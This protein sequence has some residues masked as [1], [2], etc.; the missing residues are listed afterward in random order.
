MEDPNPLIWDQATKAM[1]RRL[2]ERTALPAT[3]NGHQLEDQ[4]INGF[5]DPSTLTPEHDEP[6]FIE[7]DPPPADAALYSTLST[8]SNGR[9]SHIPTVKGSPIWERLPQEPLPFYHAY[10]YY[11]D[12]DNP[13]SLK[14]VATALRGDP[15]V[16]Y[17]LSRLWHWD[18]RSRAYDQY[19]NS[20]KERTRAQRI[21]LME[22]EH[23]EIAR[24]LLSKAKASL[25]TLTPE[26]L[27][28]ALM[29]EL[30]KTG[31][32]L[33]RLANRLPKDAPE[34]DKQDKRSH[35]TNVQVNGE[36]VVVNFLEDWRSS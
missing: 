10:T 22:T 13:R 21:V 35:D 18:A 29:L 34:E 8:T 31:T 27:T 24:K 15:E 16:V 33:E 36:Q 1:H 23:S 19:V 11:R 9:L 25:E 14:D 26:D 17:I 12:Q 4:R 30:I 7:F 6:Q 2:V 3:A 20:L 32:G 28:P 5:F